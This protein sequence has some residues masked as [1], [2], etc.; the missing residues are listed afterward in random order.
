MKPKIAILV[1]TTIA[2]SFSMASAA[3]IIWDNSATAGIQGGA[4]TW[5]T[6]S[7]NW[8]T[9]GG[10]TNASWDNSA[11]TSNTAL[12]GTSGGAVTVSETINL[13]GVKATVTGYTV[14][15]KTLAFGTAA[16]SIDTSALSTGSNIFTLSSPLTGTGGLAIAANGNLTSTGGGSSGRL[17][18]TGDNTG[19]SGGISI[20]TG[21]VAFGSQMSAGANALTLSGGGGLLVTSGSLVLN[22]PITLS[23]VTAATLR[24]WGG[25]PMILTGAISGTTGINQADSGILILSGASNFDGIVAAQ[26]G[27]VFATS[28]NS[29]TGGSA[30]SA[31]GAPTSAANGTIPVSGSGTQATIGYLGAGE[32]TDRVINFPTGQGGI[33]TNH[34]TGTF[35]LSSNMTGTATAMGV[36]INGGGVGTM[37]G[38]TNTTALINFNKQGL[39]KWTVNG[40]LQPNGGNIR[41]QGGILEFSSTS[42]TTGDAIIGVASNGRTNSGVVRFT[43]GSSIKTASANTNGILG[44]WATFDNSTW[45]VTNG[46][47]NAINGLT[48]FTTDTWAA[49]NNTDVSLAAADPASGSTTNSL[50]FNTT[51]AKTLTLAGIN[52]V[53][54]GGVLVTSNVGANTTTITGGTLIGA[55]TSDLVIHQNS[56]GGMII[57]SIIANNTGAT[58]LTKTGTGTLTLGGANTYTGTTR[59]FEGKLTVNAN[60]GGKVYEVAGA[61][62]LELGYGTGNS[63][64]GYGVTVNGAG[65]SATSGLYLKGGQTYNFQSTLRLAGAPTTVRAFGTGSPTLAGWDTNGTHLVV[66][67][68]A[69]GSV[70]SS[71]ITLAPS[72]YGYVMN[73]APGLNTLTGDVTLGGTL[74]GSSAYRKTGF[75]SVRLTGPATGG[76]TYTLQVQQGSAFLAGG[77]NR[78]STASKVTLGN[79]ADSGMLIL[80]GID[81]TVADVS[82]SG[83]GA[84]NRIVGGSATTS[85][86]TLGNTTAST[87]AATLGGI[88]ANQNNLVLAKSGA[89][90]LTVSGNNTHAGGTLISAGTLSL[91]STGALGT[92]GTIR[93][94]GGTLQFTAANTTDYSATGRLKLE[95]GVVSYFDTNG[96]NVTLSAAL[97]AGSLGTGGLGKS[98]TGGLTL[99]ADQVYTGA[100][101]VNA[102]TLTLNYA[103]ANG[104]KLSDNA[105]LTLAGG[106]L[107][108]SGGSHEEIVQSTQ[109]T[110]ISTISRSTG[111]ATINLGNITR[112][113]SNTLNILGDNIARTSMSN[114]ISGKL[115]SWIT[116]NGAPAANDGSGNIIAFSGFYNVNRLGGLIPNN[117]ANNV[118]IVN[119]GT[120]GDITPAVSGVTDIST[121]LQNADAGPAVVSLGSGDILRLGAIGS[122]QVPATSGA[123][124]IQYGT[125]TAGGA[126]DTNG[127]IAVDA[128]SNLTIASPILNNGTG[129][130]SLSK[131]GV[132]KLILAEANDLTGG[133]TL[134]AG[135]LD[136]NNP[137]AMGLNGTFTINGGTIDNTSGAEISIGDTIPQAWNADINFPGTDNLLFGPGLVTLGAN[138]IVN[139][140][141]NTLGVGGTISGAYALTKTGAG[142]LIV[143][144][145]G[146]TGLTTV[147]GGTLDVKAKAVGTADAPYVVGSGA[148]LK[149]GYN[150]DGSYA[151]TN[152]KITGD[153]TAATT[154]LYLKGTTSYNTSGTIELLGAP[155]TIRHEGSGLA[156]IGH[157]DINGNGLTTVAASSGSIIEPDIEIVSK[158]YG[159]SVNIASGSATAT[160]D[161]VI[162]GRLN[163]GS[164]GFYKRGAG[165]VALNAAAASG[166]AALKIEGGSVITGIANAIGANAALSVSSGAKLVMNGFSQ[167]AST[168]TGAGS[169]V[170]NSGTPAV[171]TVTQAA[172]GTFSGVVGGATVNERNLSLVKAGSNKLT[173]SGA[174]TYAGDTTVNA[175]TLSLSAAYLADGSD[176]RITTGATLDL[177][178]AT[179]D[180]IDELILDGTPQAAGVYGAIGSGA[181]FE[182]SYITGT[183]TLTV[184]TGPAGYSA[185]ETAN[186]ITGAGAAADSDGDG[187]PNGIEFVIGGDPSG[188]D[189]NSSAL[190]PTITVDGTYLN[191]VFRRTADSVAYD[192]FVEYG[193]TL[194]GWTLAEAGVNGVIVNEDAEFF[195]TGIDRVT[196]RIPRSLAVDSRLFG[197]LHVDITP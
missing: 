3:D 164:L 47:G 24:Q 165:S 145:K 112:T 42:T 38:I 109:I 179:T 141:N 5:S 22:N 57:N 68:T 105:V 194:A 120:S 197:R 192:P 161:L 98:G 187:I 132:G 23:G 113:G 56:S 123:L 19:L 188:P 196:V 186:G 119:G 88:G 28:F 77:A 156:Q 142:A 51:G 89:G 85:T 110:G 10:A 184:T 170:N 154:G 185:W 53:T 93:M 190:L 21:L 39:G 133:I 63:V 115:P 168:L 81:Q 33:V 80:E 60:S 69:S 83:T 73:I 15:G 64:Y 8:T 121:L 104:S 144:T 36:T 91:G 72:T 114:D 78:L 127:E 107:D 29:V 46:T 17:D 117:P 26:R 62:T 79:S 153:G 134:N 193:S 101:S 58:G 126:D 44:G 177:T 128:A 52:T 149:I 180:T 137:L 54:S 176:V 16:G 116:V 66:E 34:G 125:L 48:T 86:L 106:T 157:F 92:T 37:N 50:R 118:R 1:L 124:T 174:N 27:T 99:S 4:G 162:N 182:R 95:D 12:F 138:R 97:A 159:M 90:V 158:G 189:S 13:Q 139:V 41:M 61:G 84:N 171:L 55:N 94:N 30:T 140:A 166:N 111:G 108:L 100:T 167:S 9:D 143:A 74:T 191:F 96:Q 67:N 150:T 71:D 135:E 160:G 2:C 129:V 172:D 130:V 131:T 181:Q 40:N 151:N 148:T 49:G 6:T 169:I 147:T 45:A 102:G 20:T 65:V 136:I 7:P 122:I 75:G 11:W 14:S 35:N 155:T 103:T 70:I 163:V 195:G 183:G 87:L 76:A 175:G 59:V 18:L 31:L 43:T 25:V 178:T 82:I 152:L 32:T 146:W 173:L